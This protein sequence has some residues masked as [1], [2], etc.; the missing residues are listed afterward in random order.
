MARDEGYKNILSAQ[1]DPDFASV[2]KDPRVQE[3]LRV[4]PPYAE[5]PAKP[6][7]N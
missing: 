5:E 7:Q 4:R 1:S 3:V 2:I 6:V